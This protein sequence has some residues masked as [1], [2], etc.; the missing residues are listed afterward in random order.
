MNAISPQHSDFA[1]RL[2]RIEAGV[3]SKKQTLFVGMDEVY[4][5]DRREKVV[6]LSGG[7]KLVRAI[8]G[9]F[10]VCFGLALGAA[11]FGL[12]RVMMFHVQG[13]P[14][15][16]LNPDVSMVAEGVI[17]FAI[18]MILGSVLGFRSGQATLMKFCGAFLGVLAFHNAVLLYPEFFQTVT[19]PD[20]VQAITA[21][22]SLGSL[23][24]RGTIISL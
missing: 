9:P 3:K 6:K 13:L 12:G 24:W 16:Q 20:W 5:L 18:A 2:Q 23:S 19:S 21:K 11:S 8:F 7:Q 4:Q 1:A 15:A 17:G 22:A 14:A 10:V